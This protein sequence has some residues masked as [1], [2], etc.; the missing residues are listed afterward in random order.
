MDKL[1]K[2]GMVA[3]LY[4]PGF[5]AGW[6]TWSGSD[7]G[8]SSAEAMMF[9]R[10][11]AEVTLA[12]DLDKMFAIAKAKWPDEYHGGLDDLRVKWVPVGAQFII[13]EY[14]GSESVVLM[15]DIQFR[16]A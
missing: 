12:G 6:S 5:G 11:L 13:H 7:S 8:T 14:D 9:D 2:D 3:V 10:D 16:T 15:D 4:S 1:I